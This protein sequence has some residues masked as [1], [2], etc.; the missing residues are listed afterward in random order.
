MRADVPRSVKPVHYDLAI[1]DLDTKAFTYN[2]TVKI[3]LE[4]KEKTSA[5]SLNS[6]ELNIA[7]GSVQVGSSKCKI[8]RPGPRRSRAVI[9]EI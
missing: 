6:K 1:Y 9:D 2:G 4:L 5:I 8:F 7:E 3:H